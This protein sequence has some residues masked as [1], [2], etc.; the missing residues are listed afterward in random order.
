MRVLF[1]MERFWPAI[2]GAEIVGAKLLLALRARGYKCAV[3]T[4]Q[5]RPDLPTEDQYRGIPVYRVPFFTALTDRNV[6]HILAVRQQ[7]AQLKRI[8]APHLIHLHS[9]GSTAFFHLETTHVPSALLLVTLTNEVQ[10]GRVI[11]QGIWRRTLS[12]AAWV[13][14]KATAV[15]TQARQLVPEIIPRSSVIHNGLRFSSLLPEPLPF[16]TPSLLCLGRLVVQKGVDLVL[17]ALAAIRDRFPNIRLLV[18][19]DGPE[20]AALERQASALGLAEVVTFMGWI[21]PDKVLPLINTVTMVVMPSRWEGLPSVALQASLMAR[22]LVAT[23][24]SGLSE[25]VVHRQTGLLIE[26]EDSEGLARAITFLLEQPEAARQMGQAARQRVQEVFSWEQ[27]VN[28][29]DTLYQQLLKER[30][31]ERG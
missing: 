30:H 7:V 26:K 17:T 4:D 11:G 12:E 5:H 23:R 15:I 20:R 18:A 1:W 24:V 22:P 9:V 21:A 16:E 27:C 10:P 31:K 25:V 2:G 28:A 3:L 19:G 6:D 29:Y 13:T 14:G 8:L